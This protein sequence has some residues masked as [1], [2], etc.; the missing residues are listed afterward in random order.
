MRTYDQTCAALRYDTHLN[1]FTDETLSWEKLMNSVSHVYIALV[2]YIKL[3]PQFADLPIQC[4]AAQLKNNLNQVFG[5]NNALIVHAT[6]VVD[7]LD[8]VVFKRLFPDD[9]YQGLCRCVLDLFQFVYDPI[10]IKLLVV[11][12]I[13]STSLSVRVDT[14]QP[15]TYVKGVLAV[16]NFYIELLWRYILY[17]CSTCQRSVQ[18]L[19]AF[20]TRLLHSQV[21]HEQLS[22]Y[23]GRILPNRVDQL[24][25]IIKVMWLDGIPK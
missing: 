19:T 22:Q 4:K 9:L 14:S 15:T 8:A 21:V 13:F 18:L 5:L 1:M 12:L 23:I 7:C 10:L 3:I 24:E 6:G 20:I 11:V 2:D 17:R 16:Q 25:P